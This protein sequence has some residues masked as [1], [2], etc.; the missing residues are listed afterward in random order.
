MIRQSF[1]GTEKM[2][3]VVRI[4]RQFTT[5]DL[6]MRA[7]VDRQEA[8][9]FCRALVRHGYVSCAGKF[10]TAVRGRMPRYVLVNDP[11]PAMPAEVKG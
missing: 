7:E 5:A 1:T 6:R 8:I 9:N 2:W 4:M 10:R 11:G 3:R